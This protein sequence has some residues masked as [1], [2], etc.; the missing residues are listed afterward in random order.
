MKRRLLL[1][2]DVVAFLE[3]LPAAR[4]TALW[5]RLR[6]IAE[7]PDRFED[8]QERDSRGRDLAGHVFGGYAILYWDDFADHHLKVLEI[9]SA[10]DLQD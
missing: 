8:F 5:R 3:A 9:T 7:A 6:Q 1:D 4:R 10:D 2:S